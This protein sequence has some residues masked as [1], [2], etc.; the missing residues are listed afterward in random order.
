MSLKFGTD[1]VRGVANTELTPELALSLGRAAA[2]VLGAGRWVIGRDTRRSGPML[3][4]ALAAGLASEGSNVVDL[5]VLPTPGVAFLSAADEFAGAMISASHNDFADNG[6]KLFTPGGR[7][8]DDD[9]EAELE[10]ELVRLEEAGIPGGS[11][12]VTG[13]GVGELSR[14]PD[15]LPRYARAPTRL[16]PRPRGHGGAG[17]ARGRPT[18]GSRSTPRGRSSTVITSS[19]C[20]PSTDT[21]EGCWQ[22]TPWSSRS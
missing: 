7:K 11:T 16:G 19:L 10:A 20:V 15:A 18:G 2:R 6:I 13:A 21:S 3:A 9:T 5:G 8:L 4:A 22:R 17:P 14:G 12:R 1:G